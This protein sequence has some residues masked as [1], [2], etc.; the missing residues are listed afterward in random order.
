MKKL[1][2]GIEVDVIRRNVKSIRIKVDREGQV[3][4][5]IPNRCSEG[6]GVD[7]FIAKIDWVK[8]KLCEKPTKRKISIKN[9]EIVYIM[10]NAYMVSIVGAR[11]NKSLLVGNEI[12]FYAKK[13]DCD[14]LKA[15]YEKFLKEILI[16]KAKEYFAK[17]EKITGLKST[18]LTI[19]KTVSRWGS[20]NS[21]TGAINL[22]LYLACL[23]EF[24]LDYVV[25]HELCH[26]KYA[27]HGE[28]FKRELDKYMPN[29]KQ[30]RK[31]LKE[32]SNIYLYK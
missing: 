17:W 23:P 26:L 28:Y 13:T 32:K 30:V 2:C 8:T 11:A 20:C 18:S 12:V 29:W 16:L 31:F 5:V 1:I 10:G 24:C 6:A 15:Q 4:L 14:S 19:R 7:F 9:G 25:L 27:N 3:S 21:F 22:S